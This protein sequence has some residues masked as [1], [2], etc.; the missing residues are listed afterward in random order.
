MRLVRILSVC[1]ILLFLSGCATD[2]VATAPQTTESFVYAETAPTTI[3]TEP[4]TEASTEATTTAPTDATQPETATATMVW[5]PTNGGTKYHKKESCSN[6]INPSQV[7]QDQA[8]NAGFTP[9]KKCYK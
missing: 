9:C 4:T 3:A 7:T 8:I 6:M 1:F 2:S 5:I